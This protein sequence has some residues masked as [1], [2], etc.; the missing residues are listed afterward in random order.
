MPRRLR[1]VMVRLNSETSPGGPNVTTRPSRTALLEQHDA[2]TA[3]LRRLPTL[4]VDLPWPIHGIGGLVQRLWTTLAPDEVLGPWV[5][6][7]SGPRTSD[8]GAFT[9]EGLGITSTSDDYGGVRGDAVIT[10]DVLVHR[11]WMISTHEISD[12]TMSSLSFEIHA[13]AERL[14]ELAALVR[15]VATTSI[16]PRG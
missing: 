14:E 7:G 9:A 2:L 8:V 3:A 12:C 5:T 4:T 11:A 16:S 10:R 6:I 15:T 13:P 1:Q